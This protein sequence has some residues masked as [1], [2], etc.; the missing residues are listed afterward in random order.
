MQKDFKKHKV[1]FL[2]GGSG[3]YLQALLGKI[4]LPKVPP[5]Q[6]LRNQLTKLDKLEL[7]QLLANCDRIA[8]DKI[9]PSD[10]IRM[11]RAIEVFY[12]TG[13]TFSQQIKSREPSWK[14]LELGLNPKNLKQRIHQRTENM[15]K[16]G[17]IE[18]TQ[19]LILKYGNDL[20]LLRTI[21]YAEARSIIDGTL[22]C[23][24]GIE[25]TKQRTTQFAKRQKTW[26]KNKHNPKW[27]NDE[28]PLEDSLSSIYEVLGY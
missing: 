3:L 16:N 5:Q 1:V 21:G 7:H 12:A 18:E 23:Q 10:S 6:F 13:K 8:A 28:N 4:E 15:Y 2:V 26:F 22:S 19:A 11:I 25:I 14:I 24:E 20:Q 9:H 17:L 27:L